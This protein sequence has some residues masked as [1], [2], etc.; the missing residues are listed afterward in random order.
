MPSAGQG[1]HAAALAD[2]GL[3]F[4][5]WIFGEIFW[6]TFNLAMFKYGILLL[7]VRIFPQRWL[8]PF[9]TGLAILIGLWLVVIEFVYLFQCKPVHAAWDVATPGKKCLDAKSIYIGQS[10]PTIAF[11]L[12]ILCLPPI[13]VRRLQIPAISKTSVLAMFFLC[14]LVTIASIVRLVLIVQTPIV[15][16]TCT[17]KAAISGGF[18]QLILTLQF[19]GNF[20]FLGLWSAAEPCLGLVCSCIPTYGIL[21][22]ALWSKL[23]PKRSAKNSKPSSNKADSGFAPNMRN[24]TGAPSLELPSYIAKRHNHMVDADV[25][26][27]RS[28]NNNHPEFCDQVPRFPGPDDSYHQVQAPYMEQRFV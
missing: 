8:R 17:L 16:T 23:L 1:R 27:L 3:K 12:V 26:P 25:L 14:G 24:Q 28:A 4:A 2:H 13:L 22:Q 6:Y 9:A 10:V 18:A 11:D 15:D 21:I 19:P 7:Y 20:T 5:R